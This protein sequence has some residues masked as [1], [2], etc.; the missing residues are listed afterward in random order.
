[1]STVKE[2]NTVSV[3][4]KGTLSDGTEF[5]NSKLRGSTLEFKVGAGQMIKG[6]DNAV[7]GMGLGEVKTVTLS[8]DDAYGPVHEEAVREFPRNVFAADM[9]LEVDTIVHGEA[10]EGQPMVARVAALNEE[11]V[12]L[13]LN[14]PLAGKELTF[15]IELL[16]ITE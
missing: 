1:M 12:T 9:T 6:F 13:D 3:H 4:Y 10:G 15:E 14:H 11:T 2:G 7:V 8:S 5:D 16:D